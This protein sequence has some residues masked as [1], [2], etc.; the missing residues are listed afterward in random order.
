MNWIRCEDEMP[1]KEVAVLATIWGSDLIICE[2]GETL[3]EAMERIRKEI[4]YVTV[5]RWY[6]E[7]EGWVGAD[8][9]PM[10]VH[11]VAWAELPEPYEGEK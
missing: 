9:Y 4:R 2:D 10:V 6:G 11:P 8:G 3:I 7:K 1:N 5:A